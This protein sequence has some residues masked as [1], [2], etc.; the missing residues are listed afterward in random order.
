MSRFSRF[1]LILVLTVVSLSMQG[2][3]R[4]AAAWQA[5]PT[6]GTEVSVPG[7]DGSEAALV[8]VTAMHDAF[9]DYNPGYPPLHGYHFVLVEVSV[10]ATGA[11]VVKFDPNTLVLRDTQGFLYGRATVNRAEEVAPPDLQYTEVAPGASTAGAIGF[12]V[13]NGA[14]LADIWLIPSS[15]LFV[16]LV[17][18][19]SDPPAMLDDISLVGHDGSAVGVAVLRDIVDP[20]EGYNPDYSPDRASRY[21]MI[22]LA[23]ENTGVRLMDVDPNDFLLQDTEGFIYAA[24][25]IPQ[26]EETALP[27]LVYVQLAPGD[28]ASGV[29]GFAVLAGVDLHRVLYRPSSDRLLTVFQ[30]PVD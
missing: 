14:T 13:L 9:E 23:L 25:S 5:A 29:V 3:P 1:F 26:V 16:Q 15:D 19:V 30:F 6:L 17:E 12:Q 11:R 2:A 10:E 22:I 24:R 7:P 8:S 20:F 21:S 4:V 28:S 27:E 18:F